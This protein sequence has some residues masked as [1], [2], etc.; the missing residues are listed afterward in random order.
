MTLADHLRWW[1][2]TLADARCHLLVAQVGREAVGVVR[3]DREGA[4]AEVSIY[5]DPA[6][7]G[8]GLGPRMLEAA[9]HWA[10]G[11]AARLQRLVAEIDPRNVA[12]EAAFAAGGFSR[13]APRRWT[14]GLHA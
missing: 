2:S 8:L 7:T 13:A 5:T 4:E 9:A 10:A 3:L 14:R 12:S 11:S 1:H 6:L